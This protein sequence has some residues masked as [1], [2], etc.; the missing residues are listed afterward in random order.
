MRLLDDMRSIQIRWNDI[1]SDFWAETAWS[2]GA[3][4]TL[5]TEKANIDENASVVLVDRVELITA[6]VDIQ[7]E[8]LSTSSAIETAICQGDSYEFNA[9]LL[10]VAGVYESSLLNVQGCDSTVILDSS[11]NSLPDLIPING[12]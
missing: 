10:N 3:F 1:A 12:T 5:C 9:Q 4:L 11:I 2:D 7:T 6:N 8:I